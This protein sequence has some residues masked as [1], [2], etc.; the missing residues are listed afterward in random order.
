MMDNE[1]L[2][3][4]VVS[5]ISDKYIDEVTL[6][7]LE[8]KRKV[9]RKQ[10]IFT[11]IISATAAVF[12]L[13]GALLP[14]ILISGKQ[15]P[16]YMGMTVSNESPLATAEEFE[17][18][19]VIP[20]SYTTLSEATV[21]AR[22]GKPL[23]D[24]TGEHFN[25]T[26]GKAPYY[27]KSG[28]DIYITIKFENPDDFVILSF[29]LNGKTYSSYMFEEGS[30]MENIVLK[31]NVGD[32]TGLVSY[33]IDA[34]KYVDKD[35]IKDVKIGADR[36]V[37]IGI[38]NENQPTASISEVKLTSAGI[39]FNAG[40]VDEESLISLS[41]GKIYAIIYD[42]E[43]IISQKEITVG[44]TEG[45]SFAGLTPLSE[46]TA[47]IVAVFDA[48]DGEG[49]APHV[50]CE[51]DFVTRVSIIPQNITVTENNI[52]FD[53]YYANGNVALTK[54]ELVDITGNVIEKSDVAK[55]E[56]KNIPGG[57]YIVRI[58]Y[59][60]EENGSIFSDASETEVVVTKGMLPMIGKISAHY[61]PNMVMLPP[62]ISTWTTGHF[63]VD[64]VPTTEN[65][66]VY[67]ITDGVVTEIVKTVYDIVNLR[68][69]CGKIEILDDNGLYH[70]Y[71]FLVTEDLAVGDRIKAG[72]LLGTLCDPREND[73]TEEHHLHYECY[74]KDGDVKNYVVPEFDNEPREISELERLEKI[75][76]SEEM[77]V[78]GKLNISG[79]HGETVTYTTSFDFTYDDERVSMSVIGGENQYVRLEKLDDG[80]YAII[81]NFENIVEPQTVSLVYFIYVSNWQIRYCDSITLTLTPTE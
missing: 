42:G 11:S 39:T 64:I 1:D 40:V 61:D 58:T 51:K 31:V 8:A 22:K 81:C 56:F 62:P 71:R 68:F 49:T 21:P 7:R 69:I 74:T 36:T 72:E 41:E 3:L 10:R 73:M 35:K 53:L 19:S 45:I 63:G 5:S 26:P 24:A 33:T 9:A 52:S 80:Q 65:K 79:K 23:K 6:A 55:T 4:K 70:Y 28:E 34:I 29:T 13:L 2:K 32:V 15:V 59:S 76:L 25:A 44:S 46:Y 48:Y 67:S 14:I 38:Y 30:D 37:N 17:A 66:E 50:L 12:I 47:A 18:E 60:Y 78:S 75:A 57:K 16:I 20:L 27:A 43:T 54:I 77:L